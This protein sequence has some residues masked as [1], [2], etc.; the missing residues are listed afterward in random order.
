MSQKQVSSNLLSCYILLQRWQ[1]RLLA[2]GL[3]LLVLLCLNGLRGLSTNAHYSAY[4]AAEDPVLKQWQAFQQDYQLRDQLLILIRDPL[5]LSLQR[6]TDYHKLQQQLDALPYLEQSQ[7]YFQPLL[8]DLIEEEADAIQAVIDLYP[9]EQERLAQIQQHPLTRH[10]FNSQQ[11]SGL[12]ALSVNLPLQNSVLEIQQF[13]QQVNKAMSQVSGW[14]GQVSYFYSGAMAL[15]QSYIQVVRHD[16]KL[17]IPGLMLAFLMGLYWLFR[18]W[19]LTL[20]FISNGLLSVLLAYGLLGYFSVQLTAI[21]A[22][23]PVIILTLAIAGNLHLVLA[24][25]R[26]T[27]ETGTGMQA[28]TLAYQQTFKPYILSMLTTG[29]GFLLL[30][31]SP[32]PPVRLVG[33][34]IAL[35]MAFS[36]LLS[37]LMWPRVLINWSP[38]QS[39]INKLN[40]FTLQGQIGKS[41]LSASHKVSLVGISLFIVSLLVVSQLKIDDKVYDYFPKQQMFSQGLAALQQDFG[42]VSE[43]NFSLAVKQGDILTPEYMQLLTDFNAWLKRTI[44]EAKLLDIA[45]TLEQQNLSLQQVEQ[46]MSRGLSLGDVGRNWLKSDLSASRF[47][48]QLP[49]KTSS[50]LIAI[51]QQVKQWFAQHTVDM[52]LV[53]TGGSSADLTFAYLGQRNASNML[54]SLALA[55]V[56]ISLLTGLLFS[57]L[58]LLL[59]ATLVN[60][61]P[62]LMV[63]ALWTLAGGYISLG[64]ALVMGMVMGLIVDDTLHLLYAARHAGYQVEKLSANWLKVAPAIIASSLMIILGISLGL[65]SDFTPIRELSLLTLLAVLFALL[66][67]LLLLPALI[68]GF[69]CS[70]QPTATNGS[71]VYE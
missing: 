58:R 5:A 20:V 67:D 23:T 7:S 66:A 33:L 15:N 40:W 50:E 34:A 24:Y 46:Q 63:Y 62:L 21:N 45:S 70:N 38:H 1:K 19:K 47:V 65:V 55:L 44:P 10:L 59:I 32:S 51:E 27:R 17:F 48:L 39:L 42:A 28:L 29:A 56:V 9:S 25:A 18:S 13:M 61:L 53:L 30:L 2:G 11:N 12:I 14:Q 36:V 71:A 26:Q 37:F 54:W 60:L 22:F 16:L 31:M 52:E 35:A 69:V 3:L 4:F 8:P 64:C 6:I 68:K 49:A 43:M 57:S 41:I